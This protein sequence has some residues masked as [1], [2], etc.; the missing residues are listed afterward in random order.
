MIL[1]RLGNKKE[2]S[3]GW[4]KKRLSVAT[5][6]KKR[7]SFIKGLGSRQEFEALIGAVVDMLN[8][9]TTQI[10]PGSFCMVNYWEVAIH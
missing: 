2:I 1:A 10:I 8:P 3:E 5:V 9:N 4:S 7:L 6:R